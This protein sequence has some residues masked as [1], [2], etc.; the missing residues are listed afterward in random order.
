MSENRTTKLNVMFSE[1]DI[2]RIDDYRRSMKRIP[3]RSRTIRDLTMRQIEEE[4]ADHGRWERGFRNIV[5][6]L[7]MARLDFTIDGIVELIRKLVRANDDIESVIRDDRQTAMLKWA[8]DAFGGIENFD[9]CSVQERASRFLEEAIELCQAAGVTRQETNTVADYVY[10][11][12]A[13]DAFQ[14]VGAS[15][16]TLNCLAETLQVSVHSAEIAEWQ[17]VQAKNKSHFEQRQRDKLAAG[18]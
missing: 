1:A 2:E 13:G 17:R 4:R 18:L 5:S 12:P 10:S 11:R 6:A 16:V 3:A 8:L 14:E 15:M 7:G 9:P